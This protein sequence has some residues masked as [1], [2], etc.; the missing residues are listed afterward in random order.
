MA[1]PL[2]V[3]VV[4]YEPEIQRIIIDNARQAFIDGDGDRGRRLLQD[5]VPGM[6]VEIAITLRIIAAAHAD[7]PALYFLMV[8][9]TDKLTDGDTQ[10]IKDILCEIKKVVSRVNDRAIKG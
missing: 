9:L 10:K 4:K 5:A 8:A 3:P 7:G 1:I 2:S 6:P